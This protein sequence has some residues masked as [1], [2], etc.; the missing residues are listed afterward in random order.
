MWV[1]HFL[2]SIWKADIYCTKKGLKPTSVVSKDCH[3]TVIYEDNQGA[4]AP[5]SSSVFHSK[6]K[7]IHVRYHGIR[8]MIEEG[9]IQV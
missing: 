5:T 1:R 6:T 9:E 8:G 2:Y 7:H 3:P 4:I